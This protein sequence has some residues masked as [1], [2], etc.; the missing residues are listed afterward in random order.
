MI[1]TKLNKAV[2]MALAG[3]ALS[4]AGIS[5]ANAA[6]TTMYNLT[7]SGGDDN[8]TNTTNPTTGGSWALSG[9]TDGWIYGFTESNPDPSLNGTNSVAKW[10]GTSGANSTPFG[11]RG[12]HLNWALHM[13]SNGS[14][15][16]STFDAF[17]RYGVYADIDTAKGA[18]SD[19]A[20]S[21]AGGWRHDLDFG[22]FKSDVAGRVTLNATGILQSGT[23]FGFT[24]FKGMN[25]N[26]SYNHHGAWNAGN[27]TQAGAPN[28]ASLPGGGT[29]LPASSIVAYSV[30][31][32]SPLNLNTISFDA[33]AGQ[34]YT[35]V[36][37]GYRNGAWGDT[38]DGYRLTAAVPVPAAVWLFGSALA[39]MGV[40]GRRKN[41][42]A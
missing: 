23:N 36:L 42:A 32:A 8:S 19:N 18:W 6:A 33:E 41:K 25:S 24:I 37:G 35:V 20:L 14:A 30:G 2:V 9:N 1:K 10:A 27:N 11:Y 28:A 5:A 39:G 29:N 26:A 3:T 21:G 22:L 17:D 4:L 13:H 38:I 16:I 34:V 15:E 31:G 40:I 12:A 7:T